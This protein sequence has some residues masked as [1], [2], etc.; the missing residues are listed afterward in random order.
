MVSHRLQTCLSEPIEQQTADHD[1]RNQ[2]LIAE[3]LLP[4]K[5]KDSCSAQLSDQ[6]AGNEA[7]Q[8]INCATQTV[9]E[10]CQGINC[11]IQTV[12]SWAADVSTNSNSK[13]APQHHLLLTVTALCTAAGSSN[14][15]PQTS[16]SL[17]HDSSALFYGCK[18]LTKAA[19]HVCC[20]AEASA[21]ALASLHAACAAS[22]STHNAPAATAAAAAT[23]AILTSPS[24]QPPASQASQQQQQ[25]QQQRAGV[26]N[27][28]SASARDLLGNIQAGCSTQ[29]RQ[30]QAQ[31][32][33]A[34]AVA[35]D[36]EHYKV[37]IFWSCH[38]TTALHKVRT[39]FSTVYLQHG[40]LGLSGNSTPHSVT[41]G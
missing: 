7:C 4:H 19:V 1:L 26:V 22:T 31:Q 20:A 15:H 10:A 36:A 6:Q 38:L 21:T 39:S 3:C 37:L 11:A 18:E 40:S 33:Q 27:D 28:K 9:N 30:H 13:A 17:A 16:A 14:S 8:G 2:S 34:A 5:S 12:T 41:G 35:D 24:L 25:Q 23:A 29:Q 32:Q